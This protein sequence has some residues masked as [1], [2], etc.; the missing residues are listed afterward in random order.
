M[1]PVVD[2]IKSGMY[3][4]DVKLGQSEY[5]SRDGFWASPSNCGGPEI[6][7]VVPDCE[8]HNFGFLEFGETEREP[9]MSDEE[10][11]SQC[12][13]DSDEGHNDAALRVWFKFEGL[14]E[15]GNMSFYLVLSGGNGDAPYFRIKHQATIFECDFQAKTLKGVKS[16]GTKAIQKLLKSMK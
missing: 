12:Q 11:E 5:T 8:Q 14:Q 10:Y 16:K 4:S 1:S 2:R 9:G 13:I 3:W 15:D 7:E 6:F